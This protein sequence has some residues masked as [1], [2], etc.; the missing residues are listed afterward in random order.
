MYL[1]LKIDRR[2]EN[3][4]ACLCIS[5]KSKQS[6]F[7]VDDNVVFIDGLECIVCKNP[8]SIGF[9]LKQ[10][11]KK[12]KL[13]PKQKI[14]CM[15]SK[16]ALHNSLDTCAFQN[17]Q[18]VLH[19]ADGEHFQFWHVPSGSYVEGKMDNT[20]MRSPL[21]SYISGH[22]NQ[23]SPGV[24]IPHPHDGDYAVVVL[25]WDASQK[26]AKYSQVK[27]G[28]DV[29]SDV[30]IVNKGEWI[31]SVDVL[32]EREEMYIGFK[33]S[34]TGD[35]TEDLYKLINGG[36]LGYTNDVKLYLKVHAFGFFFPKEQPNK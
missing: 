10:K 24:Y 33:N 29:R 8:F 5:G 27:L 30:T 20:T 3:G 23:Y 17:V 28:G 26:S 13:Q 19:H 22:S 32:R 4:E 2:Y 16:G 36:E 34:F 1:T 11:L 18:V 35:S 31:I 15:L 7:Y 12:L 25:I 9:A 21:F 6:V 14:R